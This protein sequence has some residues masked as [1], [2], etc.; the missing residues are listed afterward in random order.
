M[1]RIEPIKEDQ[2]PSAILELV[3]G[4]K[5]MRFAMTARTLAHQRNEGREVNDITARNIMKVTRY[6]EGGEQALEKL[7]SRF[8]NLEKA[9]STTGNTG[10][11]RFRRPKQERVYERD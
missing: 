4:P 3:D 7:A 6:R 5:D 2:A 8:K 9:R 10:H 1:L 11:D